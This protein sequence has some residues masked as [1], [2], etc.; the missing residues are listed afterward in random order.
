M[1]QI[2]DT[3]SLKIENNYLIREYSTNG[4]SE[5]Q[6]HDLLLISN[7]ARSASG[8][9][10]TFDDIGRNYEGNERTCQFVI[11]DYYEPKLYDSIMEVRE[12]LKYIQDKKKRKYS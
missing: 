9:I 12:Q 8:R 10:I 2:V 1:L 4:I 7:V 11:P 3:E 5:K 6:V